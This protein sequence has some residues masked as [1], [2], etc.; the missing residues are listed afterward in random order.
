MKLKRNKMFLISILGCFAVPLL[1]L[2]MLLKELADNSYNTFEIVFNNS[3]MYFMML[4]GFMVFSVVCGYLFN[5]EQSEN[6]LK[7]ILTIPVSRSK[8]LISK[9]IMLFIWVLFLCVV[10][11]LGTVLVGFLG[12]ATDF[13]IISALKCLGRYLLG[14][15]LHF[16]I[17]SSLA[18]ATL[19][20]KNIVSVMVITIVLGLINVCILNDALAMLFPWSSIYLIVMH[21]TTY[22]SDYPMWLSFVIIGA[23]SILGFIASFIYFKKQDV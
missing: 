5:R 12:Q 7:T 23:V 17:L 1:I 20:L 6:T 19:L 13:K 8:Y 10:T 9:F 18:F 2:L 3:L 15:T 14:G 4:V 21:D 22:F 16:C 11:W